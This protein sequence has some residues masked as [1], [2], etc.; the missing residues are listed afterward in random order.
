V[1]YRNVSR[2]IAIFF[3][4]TMAKLPAMA[5][6][7]IPSVSTPEAMSIVKFGNP[8]LSYHTGAVTNQVP[9]FTI[10]NKEIAV[11][12]S[13]NHS[14]QGMRPREIASSV[15]HGWSLQAGGV[16]TKI[17]NGLPDNGVG[18]SSGQDVLNYLDLR[19]DEQLYREEHEPDTYQFNF[20]NHSGGFVKFPDGVAHNS[21]FANISNSQYGIFPAQPL[22]VEGGSAGF[23]ITDTQGIQY[24]F[25]EVDIQKIE[26]T[27]PSGDLYNYYDPVSTSY[28]ISRIVA[29]SGA[30]VNFTYKTYSYEYYMDVS[31]TGYY[32]EES[33]AG[34]SGGPT[35]VKP[36]QENSIC[37]TKKV[38]T[39]GKLLTGIHSN[40]GYS[41]E[42]NYTDVRQ[43]LPGG[44]DGGAL[45]QINISYNG[46]FVKGF[47]LDHFYAKTGE[48][49]FSKNRPQDFYDSFWSTKNRLFLNSVQEIGKPPYKFYYNFDYSI[50]N[51]L[52][53]AID[54]WGFYNG[55]IDNLGL[56]S[57]GAYG[58]T[59]FE[60][61]SDRETNLDYMKV[62]SLD[63]II[64]PSGGS[65][66]FEYDCYSV[67]WSENQGSPSGY[68]YIT[69]RIISEPNDSIRETFT[70]PEDAEQIN[71]Y[72][73]SNAEHTD[74]IIPQR[75]QFY[76]FSQCL[77]Y[78][79]EPDG[80]WNSLPFS[81]PSEKVPVD[82]ELTAGESYT[83]FIWVNGY[84]DE[85]DVNSR[86]YIP[87]T[88]EIR[89]TYRVPR[90]AKIGEE[91]KKIQIGG[92]RVKSIKHDPNSNS[93]LS[94]SKTIQLSYGSPLF[95]W[96]KYDSYN[97]DYVV[98]GGVP[99]LTNY[100]SRSSSS[101]RNLS[102]GL[103]APVTY[104]SVT[105]DDGGAKSS[106][107]YIQQTDRLHY[108]VGSKVAAYTNS[109]WP[110]G[111][112]EKEAH[113]SDNGVVSQK[114]FHYSGND[115]PHNFYTDLTEENSFQVY[116]VKVGIKVPEFIDTQGT[117]GNIPAEYDVE[118]YKIW[119]RHLKLN[120]IE[121]TITNNYDKYLNDTE[122]YKSKT[123]IVNIT[124]HP[125]LLN[126]I[127]KV[128]SFGNLKVKETSEYVVD[129]TG[130]EAI[131]ALKSNLQWGLPVSKEKSIYKN[132]VWTIQN[133][134]KY[135]YDIFE[136][137]PNL[138]KYSLS[139]FQ[140]DVVK[141][142]D[143]N[144]DQ[145][146]NLIDALES[147]SVEKGIIYDGRNRIIA[148]SANASSDE[149]FY[150]SFEENP[151]RNVEE[152]AKTGT[153][154]WPLS[155]GPVNISVDSRTS[156]GI[157][158]YWWKPSAEA[159]WILKRL[160]LGISDGLSIPETTG[161]V[162]EVRFYPVSASME[163][164]T[165][166]LKNTVWSKNDQNGLITYY[167]FNQINELET[168]Y[169]HEGNI[170]QYFEYFLRNRDE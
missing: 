89:I 1:N 102:M 48:S 43:D 113:Y 83:F 138:S 16:I 115:L 32:Q 127:E 128:N 150:S 125:Y 147:G 37:W 58:L 146:S 149:V 80:T 158:E 101:F 66:E 129:E 56:V 61:G 36:P 70:V 95:F 121:S 12:V 22:L 82:Y 19:D 126:E 109:G 33:S 31:E 168:I 163:S 97:Y 120:S 141:S 152:N 53:D 73:I 68:N 69:K 119:S 18:F 86:E 5:Q 143:L 4:L 75:D 136:G 21:G 148:I 155:Y 51:R 64:Y 151:N 14:N 108:T 71:L 96:P 165:Y 49:G 132:G 159:N 170:T 103:S 87:S 60:V 137:R 50:P 11:P 46:V 40:D 142:F 78:Y 63:K 52:T 54:H 130:N 17:I 44:D 55:A 77:M 47:T 59:E 62:G 140:G 145:K 90:P 3:I 124:Y 157:L 84:L 100:I 160:T 105:V 2:W 88:S 133:Q 81:Y 8:Q 161:Y 67:N 41:I 144:Y 39:E 114:E 166:H 162:D 25:D 28:Y 9:I 30:E 23:T 107:S 65:S 15:G 35:Y 98:D 6:P 13:L 93:G 112:L 20:L 72:F 131:T 139:N 27:C 74:A 29:P 154:S 123:N 34:D 118:V 24:I 91:N 76:S 26:G 92:L 10:S 117:V 156:D 94:T 135:D 104:G 110:D 42:F 164:Y 38:I 167:D 85:L 116:G 45:N 99:V 7:S 57:R 153:S 122:S 169:D 106:Y 79:H 134:S 111:T